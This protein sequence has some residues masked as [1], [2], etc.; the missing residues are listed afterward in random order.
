MYKDKGQAYT[1]YAPNFRPIVQTHVNK[2]AY[3]NTSNHNNQNSL[4]NKGRPIQLLRQI[5]TG[6]FDKTSVGVTLHAKARNKQKCPFEGGDCRAEN[7]IYRA[8][9]NELKIYIGLKANHV[10]KEINLKK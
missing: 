8:T 1:E 4:E 10:K 2:N 3:E 6:T 9:V 7:V 5:P